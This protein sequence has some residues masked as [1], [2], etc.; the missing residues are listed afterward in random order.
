MTTLEELRD[1]L[2]SAADTAVPPPG[3]MDGARR[4]VR[5]ERRARIGVAAGLT[6][7]AC[8]A[9]LLLVPDG[10]LGDPP[11]RHALGPGG[12]TT[13][14]GMT[15]ANRVTFGQVA[16]QEKV[17]FTA[18]GPDVVVLARCR[19]LMVVSPDVGDATNCGW[20]T[21]RRATAG[22]KVVYQFVA[23]PDT[24]EIPGSV[25]SMVTA[26]LAEHRPGPG[27]WT[28][29]IYSGTCDVRTCGP[30]SAPSSEPAG[31]PTTG[32]KAF[33]TVRGTADARDKDIPLRGRPAVLRLTCLDGAGWAILWRNGVPGRPIDCEKAE[34]AGTS[35]RIPATERVRIT[36]YPASVT[37]PALTKTPRPDGERLRTLARNVRPDGQWTLTAYEEPT[38][39]GRR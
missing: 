34:A 14:P 18:T 31:P 8:A 26:Y 5:R 30:R 6:A 3:L 16:N 21:I 9:A 28:I 22:A 4:R 23:V 29:E 27:E 24:V 37:N 39:P 17:E 2:R 12:P 33:A 1:T 36:V 7:A 32:L 25:E 11:G 38:G 15:L 35:W 10:D 13:T 20:R 19:G